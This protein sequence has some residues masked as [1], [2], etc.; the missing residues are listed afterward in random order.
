MSVTYKAEATEP[1]GAEEGNQRSTLI[2]VQSGGTV[3]ARIS[4]L[5]Q[6]VTIPTQAM[7]LD[8]PCAKRCI[9]EERISIKH[10]HTISY[11]YF[12]GTNPPACSRS[13]WQKQSIQYEKYMTSLLPIYS[14]LL[15]FECTNAFIF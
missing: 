11:V 4:L 2:I 9:E 15:L 5:H 3:A 6:C 14:H 1:S 8:V 7:S 13:Y 10:L 12:P